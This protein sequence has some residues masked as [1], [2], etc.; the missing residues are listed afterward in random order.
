MNIVAEITTYLDQ[1]FPILNLREYVLDHLS[2]LFIAD[3][4]INQCIHCYQGVGQN[5]KS[6][7]VN[8]ITTMM[9]DYAAYLDVAFYTQGRGKLGQA[10]P[11]LYGIIDARYIYSSETTEGDQMQEGPVKQI[12]SGTDD[13][14]ARPLYGQNVKFVSQ[15]N[16]IIQLNN[17]MNVSATDYGTWRRLRVLMFLAMFTN[18]PDVND[19]SKPFQFPIM[20]NIDQK[21][22]EWRETLAAMCIERLKITKGRCRIELCPEVRT[23]SDDYRREQDSVAAFIAEKVTRK[24]GGIIRRTELLQE[25]GEWCNQLGDRALAGKK[26]K[27]LT[28]RMDS[29]YGAVKNAQ[30]TGVSIIYE[31]A[32][33]G[34][35]DEDDMDSLDTTTKL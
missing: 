22:G 23:A 4:S 8:L 34:G 15:G 11:D 35:D 18:T 17:P 10:N 5:G 25:F 13:M 30:W 29:Q 21:F 19:Q 2:S 7:F 20:E 24:T 16:P 1:T 9:G 28:C 26:N 14:I 31:T 6:K 12:S 32:V 3:L 33:Y 27:Q